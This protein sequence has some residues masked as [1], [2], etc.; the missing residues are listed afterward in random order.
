MSGLVRGGI[1]DVRTASRGWRWGRRSQVPRS[2]EP[3]VL[4]AQQTV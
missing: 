1:E 2:A 3:Y 4:P